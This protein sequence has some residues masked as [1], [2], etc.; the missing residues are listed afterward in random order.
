MVP[1]L[2]SQT[3]GGETGQVMYSRRFYFQNNK[4]KQT[5]N[6][7]VAWTW[8]TPVM[9]WRAD[10]VC[11][12]VLK[13]VDPL[14]KVWLDH[15]GGRELLWNPSLAAI[16]SVVSL[17]HKES[18]RQSHHHELMNWALLPS[19][20]QHELNPLENTSQKTPLSTVVYASHFIKATS[21]VT[22]ADL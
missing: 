22:Q 11:S 18:T 7:D 12:T 9:F 4:I 20:P 5:K 15:C 16:H 13:T 14:R 3:K 1:Y 17:W 21:H 8:N 10:L 2:Q 19:L 6:T